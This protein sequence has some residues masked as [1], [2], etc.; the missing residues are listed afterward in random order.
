MKDMEKQ[1]Q[2]A[3][4]RKHR[5]EQ[6]DAAIQAR[7]QAASVSTEEMESELAKLDQLH[8]ERERMA[9]DEARLAKSI[10][11]LNEES[12]GIK[13][14][15]GKGGAEVLQAMMSGLR[16]RKKRMAAEVRIPLR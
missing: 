9:A 11:T 3:A 1:L 5:M 7:M 4:K 10:S 6:D 8:V 14:A 13:E 12:T 16:Q 2:R 15:S